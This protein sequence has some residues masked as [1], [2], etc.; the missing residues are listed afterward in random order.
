MSSF[1]KLSYISWR[2]LCAAD[3]SLNKTYDTEAGANAAVVSMKEGL[4]ADVKVNR[5]LTPGK[6]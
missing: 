6:K 3:P 1:T 5:G 4:H 2:I